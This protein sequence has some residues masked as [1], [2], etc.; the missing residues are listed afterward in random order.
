MLYCSEDSTGE[1]TL[2][3]AGTALALQQ[4]TLPPSTDFN[5]T[6]LQWLPT[7]SCCLKLTELTVVMCCFADYTEAP[8]FS[9][10]ARGQV[11]EAF[12]LKLILS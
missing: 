8:S 4:Q 9:Y 6:I 10:T 5:F 3:T 1:A 11:S 7:A 2:G 12:S